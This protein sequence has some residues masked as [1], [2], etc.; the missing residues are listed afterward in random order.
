MKA[1][2]IKRL[3]RT[4][5]VDLLN[6]SLASSRHDDHSYEIGVQNDDF[7]AL[8]G[9]LTGYWPHVE[10][11][12]ICVLRDLIAGHAK[13]PARQIF[14]SVISEAARI[15]I[16]TALLEHSPMNAGKNQFYDK[17]IFAF[18]SLNSKRN[19]M[20]HGVWWTRDDGKIFVSKESLD[21]HPVGNGR[22]VPIKELS[23]IIKKMEGLVK[24][25]ASHEHK[26]NRRWFRETILT[27]PEAR[28]EYR[29]WACS[30]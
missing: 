15:R 2:R 26:L 6:K 19:A 22:P 10:E 9:K 12:M 30:R 14:R 28:A 4:S 8:L 29:R 17:V 1:M 16:M 23:T 25:L 21:E 7:A 18:R 3:K 13:V 11:R 24:R 5:T 20:V 27:T